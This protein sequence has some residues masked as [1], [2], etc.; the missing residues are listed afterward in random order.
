MTL[1]TLGY[2]IVYRGAYCSEKFPH[3]CESLSRKENCSTT[4]WGVRR[5]CPWIIVAE[6][7]VMARVE[8]VLQM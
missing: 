1:T 2:M 8:A 7:S 6:R 4:E 5:A 3:F